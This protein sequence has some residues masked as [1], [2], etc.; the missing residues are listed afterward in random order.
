MKSLF[1]HKS[2]WIIA[3]LLSALV[4]ETFI[5]IYIS[6]MQD[7]TQN[8]KN[9]EAPLHKSR[10]ELSSLKDEF[11]LQKLNAD[12]DE[13]RL[14]VRSLEKYLVDNESS[15]SHFEN[16]DVPDEPPNSDKIQE[17]KKTQ[18]TVL[19]EILDIET[20]DK[21]WAF[22]TEKKIEDVLQ[23]DLFQGTNLLD[24]QCRSTICKFEVEHDSEESRKVF[25]E[26]FPIKGPE[27][28]QF[29]MESDED[30]DSGLKS[31]CFLVRRGKFV[32][33]SPPNLNDPS[34]RIPAVFRNSQ[35]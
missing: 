29:S 30:A 31:K 10:S 13:L 4:I 24:M 17:Y 8:P 15:N 6:L 28:Q 26:Q 20:V 16:D 3:I 12:I 34:L 33:H 9:M 7:D 2:S 27:N 19:Q 32:G 25:A 22:G 11:L 18:N 21:D 5:L 35:K 14:Q 1:A 23:S